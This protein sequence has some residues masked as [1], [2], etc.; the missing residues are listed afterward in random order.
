MTLD[1]AIWSLYR[2]LYRAEGYEEHQR[3]IP[4]PGTRAYARY[5]DMCADEFVK[6]HPAAGQIFKNAIDRAVGTLKA[7]LPRTKP[8]P[9][10]AQAIDFIPSVGAAIERLVAPFFTP[11]VA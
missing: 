8:G 1:D 3:L 4:P 2:D 9:F 11:E 10:G 7:A 6:H 5:L